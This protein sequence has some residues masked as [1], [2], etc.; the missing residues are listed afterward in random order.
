[1]QGSDRLSLLSWWQVGPTGWHGDL[2][3]EMT[4]VWRIE[5]VVE[6]Q[7]FETRERSISEVKRWSRSCTT[8]GNGRQNAVEAV[9]E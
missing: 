4:R 3:P 9:V 6:N 8:M 2:V 1:M 7:Y 5:S